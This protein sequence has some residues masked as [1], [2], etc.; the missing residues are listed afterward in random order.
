MFARL[1]DLLGLGPPDAYP[2][3]V[4][5][6]ARL[7]LVVFLFVWMTVAFAAFAAFGS[8]QTFVESLP[9]AMVAGLATVVIATLLTPWLV[10]RFSRR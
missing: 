2:T 6:S 10:R 5:R 8:D 4:S 7:V 3:E 9:A 1:K